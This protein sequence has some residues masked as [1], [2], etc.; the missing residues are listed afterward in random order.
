V[1]GKTKDGEEIFK[2]SKVYMP[3][4]GR[5]AR[6]DKMGRGPYE[7]SGILRDTALPPHKEV[8]ESYQIPFPAE[9]DNQGGKPAL[10]KYERQMTV[11]VELW[12][13]P[14]GSKK[15]DPFL[16]RKVTKEVHLN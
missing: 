14:F 8:K 13:L 1:T 15:D 3:V 6:G 11:D 7:K 9:Y 16:F 4:P 2:E 5:M 10:K 12:Y